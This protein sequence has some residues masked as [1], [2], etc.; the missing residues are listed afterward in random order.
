MSVYIA[1]RKCCLKY[2]KTESDC[3]KCRTIIMKYCPTTASPRKCQRACIAAY[4]IYQVSGVF[5][6]GTPRGAHRR[7]VLFNGPTTRRLSVCIAT[8]VPSNVI[9]L[10][11]QRDYLNNAFL[12]IIA[13]LVT[14]G[15][16]DP[17]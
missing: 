3:D 13:G 16:T 14:I 11:R 8:I 17:V 2:D 15:T 9:C 12:I 7:Q 1:R 4:N 10:T 5:I 6:T